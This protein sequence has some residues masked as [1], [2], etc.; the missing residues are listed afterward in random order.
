MLVTHPMPAQTRRAKTFLLA[1]LAWSLGLFAL[2]RSPWVEQ[3]VVLPLT[4]LQKQAAD[5]YAGSP[6][7]PVAVTLE[8]SGT[9][10]LALC[11]GAILACPVSWR[12][13]FAGASGAVAF[14]LALNTVRIATLGHAAASPDLF[15]LLHLQVW[16]AILV[17]G[18][19]AYVFA[20]M[21]SALGP[22]GRTDSIQ[23]GAGEGSLVPL[24]RRF[25]PR[26]AAL[27]A[28][29]ALCAPWIATSEAL[30]GAGAW[31]AR[32]AAFILAAGGMAAAASGNVL[33]T[34][35]GDFLVTPECLAS[36]LIP[37]YVAG[38]LTARLTWPGRALALVAA[39]P[40]FAALAIARLLLL[41]VPPALAGSPLFLVHGFHQLVLAVIAVVLLARWLDPTVPRTW[42][43]AFS[44]A[45]SALAAATVFAIVAGTALAS[46]VLGAARTIALLAPH[47]ITGLV[48]PGDTQGA[49]ALL[50]AFQAGLLLALGMV[51]APSWRRLLSA[52]GVLLASQVGLLV[53][54]GEMEAHAGLVGHALLLRAWAVGVP[55]VLTLGMLAA[56]PPAARTL[57]PLLPAADAPL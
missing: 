47:T 35:R 3:R 56:R 51:A 53:V 55:I 21:R 39:P 27:L 28:V 54:L 49:L 14:V 50:P 4:L 36:A 11:L 26:A 43:R 37:L 42:T 8:C 38:V 1:A 12:A 19:A 44:R 15:R 34:S 33:A 23:E 9:D 22:A 10:V 40:L 48:A 2:L 41:A 32:T 25:V 45:G 13:R 52:F 30:Q 16:P 6:P 31:M 29:F 57:A 20:W 5:Y 24:V 7:V 18:T 46:V 17:L